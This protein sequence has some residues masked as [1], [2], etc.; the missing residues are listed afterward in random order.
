MSAK[1]LRVTCLTVAL[2]LACGFPWAAA[3]GHALPCSPRAEVL[4]HLAAAF[5][6][7]PIAVGFASNGALLE[8]L[9]SP[10]GASWTVILS[11][12]N[13]MSCLLAAG[14]DWQDRRPVLMP[15]GERS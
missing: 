8:L 10:D 11:A 6:E 9:A 5:G 13:G 4:D 2:A 12:A 15:G 1:G 3:R 14:R 7:A